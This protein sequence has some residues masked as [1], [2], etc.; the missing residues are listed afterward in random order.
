MFLASTFPGF[1]FQAG[2]WAVLEVEDPNAAST[3]EA[4]LEVGVEDGKIGYSTVR[5]IRRIKGFRVNFR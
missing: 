1:T 2:P 3:R 4:G 5:R